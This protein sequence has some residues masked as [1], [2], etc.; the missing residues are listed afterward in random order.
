MDK[1]RSTRSYSTPG[2]ETRDRVPE[3]PT[4]LHTDSPQR[5]TST[6]DKPADS[7]GGRSRMSTGMIAAIVVA[8]AVVVGLIVL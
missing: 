3:E 2:D 7:R 6:Y 1:P 5:T 8:V 4:R